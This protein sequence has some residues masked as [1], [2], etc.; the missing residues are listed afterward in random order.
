MGTQVITIRNSVEKADV[1]RIRTITESTGF[2][3][4]EEVDTAVELIED[5]LVKGPRC[6]YH[7]LF[8]E[9][10]GR[11]V[12]YTSYGPIACT[13]TSFDLYWIVVAGDFRGKGLGTRLLDASESAI[14]ALGG[15]RVYI[16]TSMRPLYE[17]TRAFYIARG[18]TAVAVLDDFYAPGDAKVI[19]L[20]VI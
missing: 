5:R 15:N 12:G 14:Q 19:Y 13:R 20:K 7:F 6:G 17:P 3:Y 10:D 4:S 16:E 9:E 18:Y 11:T 2:F 1:E 8:A